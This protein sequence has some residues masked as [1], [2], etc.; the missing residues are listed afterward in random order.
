MYLM[1]RLLKS[2]LS[3]VLR[4]LARLAILSSLAPFYKYRWWLPW[5]SK[6]KSYFNASKI[7]W[8]TSPDKFLFCCERSGNQSRWHYVPLNL[9]LKFSKLPSLVSELPLITEIL[10]DFGL[11]SMD[12]RNQQNCFNQNF[13]WKC[14]YSLHILQ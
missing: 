7:S 5:F 14:E 10:P 6:K 1:V 8:Q 4:S 11:S 12:F 3:K 13:T 9:H 2:K